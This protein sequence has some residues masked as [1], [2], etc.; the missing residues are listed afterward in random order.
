MQR[1][2]FLAEA[3]VDDFDLQVLVEEYVLGFD[4]TVSHSGVVDVGYAGGHC[5]VD[6]P[7]L[8]L[9]QPALAAVADVLLEG[10]APAVLHDQVDL[11]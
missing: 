2:T 7:A 1:P 4:V 11:S 10:V 9:L 6:G 3:E 5:A 8:G